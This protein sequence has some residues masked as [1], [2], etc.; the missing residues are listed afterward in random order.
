[1]FVRLS[2]QKEGNDITS[3]CS[4]TRLRRAGELVVKRPRSI[5]AV[6]TIAGKAA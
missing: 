4:P 3:S 5:Y 6:F 1:M 2:G